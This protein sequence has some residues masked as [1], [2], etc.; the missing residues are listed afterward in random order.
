M[1]RKKGKLL[2]WNVAGVERK[3]RIFRDMS[4]NLFLWGQQRH[5]RTKADKEYRTYY[6]RDL[7]RKGRIYRKM[8]V[9]GVEG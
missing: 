5:K 2:F 1:I 4:K 6:L 8:E 7:I 9:G 3:I